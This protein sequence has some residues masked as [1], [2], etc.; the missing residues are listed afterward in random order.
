MIGRCLLVPPASLSAAVVVAALLLFEPPAPAQVSIRWTPKPIET[1]RI[2]VEV[3]GLNST[4]VAHL[5]RA[6]WSN[7]Q[8][9]RLLSVQVDHEDTTQLFLPDM[10][11]SYTISN[12]T[13][14]FNPQFPLQPGIRYRAI[15]RPQNLPGGASDKPLVSTFTVPAI[16]PT[17]LASVI[18][19]FPSTDQV[20]E[21]LLKFYVCFSG[22]M[23]RG[24]IYDYIHLRDSFG[25]EVE[26]PFLQIDEE[27]WNADMTRL[28]LFIDPGRIK[29]GVRPLEEVGPA[30]EAGKKYQLIIDRQWKDA[31]GHPLKEMF[32]KTFSVG[33]PDRTPVDPKEWKIEI[34]KPQTRDPLAITFPKPMDYALASRMIHIVR[35]SGE[36]LRGTNSLVNH[37]QRWLFASDAPWAVSKYVVA[38]QT[39]IEDL[40]GNNIG[41]LFEVDLFEGVKGRFTNSVVKLPFEVR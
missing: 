36:S 3:V 20:P 33:P 16:T 35:D 6:Q 26:L 34:P 15:F 5:R 24:N 23:S 31:T 9:H 27:L 29:R 37:E 11:G 12:Q 39:T 14:R 25:K 40:A 30:L 1:N 28:T 38:V 4:Q 22:P 8:W 18:Q 7:D 17:T 21:N 41:K 10:L 19:I 13:P 32:T 2:A